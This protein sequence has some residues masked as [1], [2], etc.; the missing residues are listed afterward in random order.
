MK[1]SKKSLGKQHS[2][3]SVQLIEKDYSEKV[4]ADLI[5]LTA[6]R[7][8]FKDYMLGPNASKIVRHSS[9]SVMVVRD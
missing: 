3:I 6:V 5:M 1:I 2:L 9:I 4:N 7:P 8:Q